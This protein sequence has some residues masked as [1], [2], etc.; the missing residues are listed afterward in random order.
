MPKHTKPA[1]ARL[2]E[3]PAR[4]PLRFAAPLLA[5][6]ALCAPLPL[7]AYTLAPEGDPDYEEAER[8][9][10]GPA[11]LPLIEVTLDPEDFD[12]FLDDPWQ[13]EYRRCTVRFV[14][15][16]TDET[17]RDVGI[18]VR[19]NT[20]RAATK[21]SWKL[22]F[23]TFV[24]GRHFHGMEKMNLNGDRN[25]PSLVR[26][27]LAFALYRAVGVPAPRARHVRLKI[28][29]GSEVEGVF[30]LI[31]QVDEEFAEA[32]FGN[33]SGSLYK[34]LYKEDRAD[35][36]YVAPGDGGTYRA[37]GGGETYGEK[38][39]DAP[40]YEDLAAF[41]DFV[42]HAD[43]ET[44]AR[45]LG[46]RFALDDFLRALA[47][48]L[49]IGNWDN[50][51]YG[52]NNYYLYR[53]EANGLFEWIPHDMDNTFGV[54]F[55]GIN[56]ASRAV[57]TWGDGGFGSTGGSL[58]PLIDRVLRVP[59]FEK[60]LRGYLRDFAIVP[61]SLSD[62]EPFIER[63]R[64]SI[65]PFVF[66]GSYRNGRMDWGYGKGDFIDAFD[67]PSSFAGSRDTRD[68]GVKPFIEDRAR[69]VEWHVDRPGYLPFLRVNEALAENRNG[70]RDE[71]GEREDWIEIENRWVSIIDLGGMYLTDDPAVP[72]KWRIPDGIRIDAG[73]RLRFWCDGETEEGPA[74]AGFRLDPSGAAIALVHREEERNTV[75]DVLA[76]RELGADVSFGRDPDHVERTGYSATP[77]PGAPNH[78]DANI[79]PLLDRVFCEPPVPRDDEPFRIVV[80]ARD[81]DGR[82]DS[83]F[84]HVGAGGETVRL[85]MEKEG[86][87]R[88]GLFLNGMPEG[89]R[90]AWHVEAWDDDGALSV[91]PPGAPAS[92]FG[93]VVEYA[94]PP[95][96][97]NEIAAGGA[98]G[99][100][101]SD[102]PAGGWIEIRNDGAAPARLGGLR[103]SAEPDT[104]D[105][106]VLPEASLE[107]G[108]YLVV[109]CERRAAAAE[110]NDWSAPF[111]LSASGGKVRLSASIE[112]G[113]VTIDSVV[114]ESMEPGAAWG[115][116]GDEGLWAPLAAATPGGPNGAPATVPGASTAPVRTIRLSP[117]PVRAS[118]GSTILFELD[119]ASN[120]R[121]R[122]YDAAG[123]LAAEVLDERLAPGPRRIEWSPRT[124]AG[125][126]LAPGV[127]FL[128]VET[129]T[130]VRTGKA[131]L[132][133]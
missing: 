20:S 128:R 43:D 87:D 21:K 113:G 116:S 122:L 8:F 129:E 70:D 101:A 93:C 14:N 90:I 96:F 2:F 118:A 54:D 77:T 32:W 40:D 99:T 64:T 45:E 92:R 73:E 126:E 75:V 11:D 52:A 104:A 131:V 4:L 35:L 132:L 66:E 84:L 15:S 47:V 114:Y 119:R 76:Y 51:W 120:V 65:T 34:C 72:K 59:A 94:P 62:Q 67:Y 9:V 74:H 56:W 112:E 71:A 3:G 69:W 5:V 117:H 18:R 17:V 130:G 109:R 133:R 55:F 95:L 12:S 102:E 58:P 29:D 88:Y 27:S 110:A 30:V 91:D 10:F 26:S 97:L 108:G 78:L 57:E 123:R 7:A 125:R 28:N 111:L 105:V 25:D 23:N 50:Y 100:G 46:N 31:E 53:N 1:A 61:V 48:D 86:G 13:E 38:N 16:L 36:R 6:W 39:L 19:G 68:Y 107:P 24:S 81:L 127:Y 33:K 63:M 106:L 79:P 124:E 98:E 41:I 80:R 103:I 49:L 60:R 22:S 89:T 83:V 42:N 115:R 44:F 121:I 82:V 85:P 37:L